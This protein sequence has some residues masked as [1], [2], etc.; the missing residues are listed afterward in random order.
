MI[1]RTITWC[2]SHRLLVIVAS[3]ALAIWGAWAMQQPP[4]DAI[5]DLSDVQV[6]ISTEWPGRSPDLIEDQITY[7][8]VTG[9]VSAPRVR[10]VRG[11]TDF[12]IS[13][14]YV[15]FEDGTDIY[16]ARSRVLEYLQGLR[17]ALPDGATPTMAPDATGA[18][19]VFEY[20][21]VDESG[22]HSVDELRSLQDW[23]LRYGIA[24]VRG[25]AEVASIG[26]FVKQYQI[27][28]DPN[29]L[30][31]HGLSAMQVVDAI[32]ASN[33]NVGGRLLE[34]A[35]REYMVRA[36]GYLTS[37]ADIEQVSLGADASGTPI[38]VVDVAKVRAGPE[39]RR[40]IAE[41]DGRGEAVGGIVIMRINENALRVVEDVKQRIAEIVRTLPAGVTIVP[42]YDRSQFIRASIATLRRVL[43]EEAI[44][45]AV[46]ILIFLFHVRAA[47]LSVVVLP[48]TVLVS[49]IPLWYW[50]I[51]LNIMSLGGF[52]LAI[53][54][55][56]DASIVMVDNAYRRV[57]EGSYP[58]GLDQRAVVIDAARQIARPVVFS[59]AIIVMSFAPVFLLEGQ[60]GR[61][62]QPLALTKTF[63]VTA[64]T[65]L[66]VTLVPVLM[67]VLLAG[68]TRGA[69]QPSPVTRFFARLY[70]PALE[71]ALRWKWSFLAANLAL[72]SLT[73]VLALNLGHEFMPPL[74]EG[75][76][77]Y[78]PSA[79]P[80]AA[81]TD[82]MRILQ[83]QDR[84]L[85]AFPEVD[86]VFG[87]AGRAT[88]P[89]DN[90]PMSMINT[91]VTLKPR[92]QW[93]PGVTLDALVAEMDARLRIPGFSNVW[94]QPI[95]GRL[96]ML[97]TGIK[98]PVGLKILGTDVKVVQ[99]L[100]QQI[101]K[102]LLTLPDT[103]SAYAE[104]VND[105]Y[106]LDIR[107]D[108]SAIGRYGLTIQDVEDVVQT[109]IGGANIS[110]MF[111]GRERYPINVR[112]AQ[113]YRND[114]ATLAHV[115]VKAPGGTQVPLGQLAVITQTTGPSMIRDENGQLAAYVYV[116][117]ASRDLAG[118]VATARAALDRQLRLPTGYRLE[119]SGQYESLV[120]AS[121]RLRTIIPIVA[122]TI[123]GLLYLTFWSVGEAT[124]VMLSVVYAMTGGLFL[125]WLFGYS[126]SVAVW[127]GY[128]TLY[129]VAV[130]TGVI[131]IVYMRDALD[132][133]LSAGALPTEQLVYEA[134]MAGAV[135][136][137]R[138]KLM[139][140]AATIG[141]LLPIMWSTGI[142]SDLM[143]PIA[144]P[145]IGG[146]VTSAVHVLFITPILFFLMKRREL[147]VGGRPPVPL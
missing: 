37:I 88:T 107:I 19:W 128:I 78:M 26:G 123:F 51:N 57:E 49:F 5:P 10:S 134:T 72:A 39:M 70:Q 2:V 11:L 94:T 65:L 81:S 140:V 146:M 18:G 122:L 8:I 66:A 139:T 105:G 17:G 113:D 3:L 89:T 6:I 52:A 83:Q 27:T 109:A 108:R 102:I 93:R 85:K 74:F 80:G 12:G 20:A 95:R 84:M 145:I 118:Y 33:N 45:V 35:G 31:V 138:P 82:V 101:E 124:T 32:R 28:L 62:F 127:V 97:D 58:A 4:F 61:L 98:T 130:Q 86:S 63:A 75:A 79:P 112:Y 67:T 9:L 96:D 13:F 121:A 103:R 76:L 116:D 92:A 50:G 71:F 25:V 69:V 143:R 21:L 141:S 73:I 42:T 131:M 115:L 137:L 136:R 114:L 30:S 90:S 111:E 104:R 46:V 144:V 22:R 23:T 14:V 132:S 129:G 38:R 56:V 119:W 87:T 126:F 120:R 133:R 40:G 68:R 48:V 55:L 60:E 15:V 43:I 36:I 135:L 44:V 29:Q 7:P 54:V 53:G 106:F 16:W 99:E 77:L 110:V 59:L 24:S 47:L 1:D 64:A 91:M 125:Q 34:F 147:G 41:L 117:T 100:G 142:G